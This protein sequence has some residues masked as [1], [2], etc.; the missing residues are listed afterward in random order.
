MIGGPLRGSAGIQK[1]TTSPNNIPAP[2]A[3]NQSFARRIGIPPK[4]F[5]SPHKPGLSRNGG[6]KS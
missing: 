4:A 1:V 3:I 6:G 5:A 2:A